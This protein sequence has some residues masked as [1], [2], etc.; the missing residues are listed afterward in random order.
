MWS[1]NAPKKLPV[2][3]SVYYLP[4]VEK[5]D[6]SVQCVRRK[7]PFHIEPDVQH[8]QISRNPGAQMSSMFHMS[9]SPAPDVQLQMSSMSSTSFISSSCLHNL[10]DSQGGRV[11]VL[12]SATLNSSSNSSLPTFWIT[13]STTSPTLLCITLYFSIQITFA[14]FAVFYDIYFTN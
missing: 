14:Y 3:P 2:C 12:N 7:I 4:D 10:L 8:V 1:R 11:G 5:L 9:R 6:I 13:R